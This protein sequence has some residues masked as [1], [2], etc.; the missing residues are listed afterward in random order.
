MAKRKTRL[1]IVNKTRFTAF[2]L[3]TAGLLCYGVSSAMNFAFATN[4]PETAAV[5]VQEGDTLWDIAREHNP[6]GKDVRRLVSEIKIY[7]G[8]QDTVIRAGDRLE[9]PLT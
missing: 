7:N 3:V 6:G 5:F 2:C 9:I 4:A 8:L 1:R